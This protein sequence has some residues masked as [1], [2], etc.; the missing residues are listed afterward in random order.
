MRALDP[1][2]AGGVIRELGIRMALYR[3]QRPGVRSVLLA[4]GVG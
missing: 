2:P 1:E 4:A 3:V